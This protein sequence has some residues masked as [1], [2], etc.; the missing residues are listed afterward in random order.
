MIDNCSI[1]FVVTDPLGN[2]AVTE[3]VDAS[4]SMDGMSRGATEDARFEDGTLTVRV[5]GRLM[6]ADALS[7]IVW[8]TD[9]TRLGEFNIV[10]SYKSRLL[11]SY[12]LKLE[13]YGGGGGR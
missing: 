11:N 5:A 3:R 1:S 9:G 7:V 12:T 10:S 2:E 13:R 4:F 6:R 8:M